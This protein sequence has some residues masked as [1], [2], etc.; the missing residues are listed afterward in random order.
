LST[1]GENVSVDWI[2]VDAAAG[3]HGRPR[4]K[5]LVTRASCSTQ[6]APMV[7]VLHP[8]AVH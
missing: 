7:S 4:T 1:I 6:N 3:D 5:T 8:G 2:D